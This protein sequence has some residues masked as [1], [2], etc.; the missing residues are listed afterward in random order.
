PPSNSKSKSDVNDE[1]EAE[2]QAQQ[3]LRQKRKS[4]ELIKE[5]NDRRKKVAETLADRKALR[6]A[7][8]DS[9]ARG[10][11]PETLKAWKPYDKEADEK[12]SSGIIVPLL[13][14]GIKKYDDVSRLAVGG[15]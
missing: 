9:L 11:M 8:K 14:F 13:P 15:R 12:A 6:R 1:K 4:G 10:E 5:A 3:A 7:E 2:F